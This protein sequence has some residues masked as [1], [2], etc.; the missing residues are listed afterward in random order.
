MKPEEWSAKWTAFAVY[1]TTIRFLKVFHSGKMKEYVPIT[2]PE[3]RR[4]MFESFWGAVF[5]W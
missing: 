1:L 3:P 4:G 2:E 5:G